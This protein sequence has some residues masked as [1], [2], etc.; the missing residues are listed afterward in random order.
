MAKPLTLRQIREIRDLTSQVNPVIGG[1]TCRPARRLLPPS[2][3]IFP[4]PQTHAH[5]VNVVNGFLKGGG[6]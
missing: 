3:D 5:G 2:L 1:K 6:I 4:A